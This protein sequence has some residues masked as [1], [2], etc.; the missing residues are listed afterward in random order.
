MINW[1]GKYRTNH[2]NNPTFYSQRINCMDVRTLRKLHGSSG[3]FPIICMVYIELSQRL[4][5]DAT[6]TIRTFFSRYILSSLS[7]ALSGYSLY[8][9]CTM[10]KLFAAKHMFDIATVQR[11]QKTKQ[12]VDTLPC[13]RLDNDN[14]PITID[15]Y[16][17]IDTR[18]F[19]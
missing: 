3:N 14:K 10:N 17:K 6:L 1:S 16:M 15:Q 4:D 7:F 12:I 2:L 13:C 19:I 9:V 5:H 11:K 8:F 18:S